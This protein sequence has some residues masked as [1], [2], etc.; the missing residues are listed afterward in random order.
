MRKA[1]ALALAFAACA[2]TAC[3]T[4]T[5]AAP[6]P[7]TLTAAAKPAGLGTCMPVTLQ[8]S[9]KSVITPQTCVYDASIGRHSVYYETSIP[10][11]QMLTLTA[12]AKFDGLMGVKEATEDPHQGFV[13]GS[14]GFS[15]NTPRK[16]MYIGHTPQQVF[17]SNQGAREYGKFDLTA[18]MEPVAYRCG[19]VTVLE[20]SVH[21]S[22]AIVPE[23]ACLW[24]IQY[25]A[26][27]PFLGEPILGHHYNVKM[28]GGESYEIRLEGVSPAFPAVLAFYGL[29]PDPIV[30]NEWPVP[31]DG[32]RSLTVTADG[33]G[34]FGVEVSS[35]QPDGMGGW[36]TPSGN[37]TLSIT[38]L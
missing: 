26:D 33:T 31:A 1:P 13:R 17:V 20:A 35:G 2:L 18:A 10:E 22:D 37:F 16:M 5:P 38:P 7:E 21:F 25:P 9:Q 30:L 14:V 34:Y 24:T 11:G 6:E 28:V 15:A 3:D 8:P 23:R 32:V 12:D 29:G 19:V 36:I 27:N 4:T